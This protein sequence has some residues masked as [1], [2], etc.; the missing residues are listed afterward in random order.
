MFSQMPLVLQRD[1]ALKFVAKEGRTTVM[2]LRE[3]QGASQ[4]Q[5][6]DASPKFR[7]RDQS[8]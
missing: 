2:S 6:R 1:L 4:V 5:T 8:D 7:A 3:A